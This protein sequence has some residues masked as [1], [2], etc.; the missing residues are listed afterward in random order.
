MGNLFLSAITVCNKITG[1]L[2]IL[3]G[4]FF[5]FSGLAKFVSLPAFH[6]V[7]AS[8]AIVPEF[9]RTVLL[10]S[11]PGLECLL[12]VFLLIKFRSAATSF[13]LLLL[14]FIFT[15]AAYL[16]YQSGQIADCGCFGTL[17]ERKNDWKLFA[18][19]TLLMVLLSVVFYHENGYTAK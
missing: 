6:E 14:V 9:L 19:N 4:L 3:L 5:V 11:I 8:Y 2:R 1:I 16:K 10:Y 18:G 15:V 17:L 13:M 12:G 7:L